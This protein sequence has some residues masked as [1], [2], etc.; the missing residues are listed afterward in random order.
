MEETQDELGFHALFVELSP[1]VFMIWNDFKMKYFSL[2]FRISRL[3]SILV[4]Q[5]ILVGVVLST[6]GHVFG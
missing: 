6:R 3:L 1:F 5:F 4:Y 2:N